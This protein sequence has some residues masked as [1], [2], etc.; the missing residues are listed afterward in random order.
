MIIETKDDVVRLSGSLTRNQWMTI[1]AAANLLLTNHPEGIIVDCSQLSSISEDGAKTFLEA[2]RD[3][4]AA[5][6]RILVVSLPQQVLAVCKTVPG[7][8]SQ[9]PIADTIED[10]R[11]SLRM[12][13][14]PGALRDKK[15]ATT[16]PAKRTTNILVP[17]VANM[18]LTYG[19]VLAARV[20][21]G[22]RAD[23]RLVYFL[24]VP[25]TLPL[26]A[27]LVEEEQSAQK[28]LRQAVESARSEGAVAS[29]HVERVRDAGEGILAAAKNYQVEILVLGATTEPSAGEQHEKFH[30]LVDM[31]I[32]RAPCEVI[33]GRQTPPV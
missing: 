26:N 31:L 21:R 20:S 19:A 16:D 12:A 30:F 2:M 8:R 25:R 1:K 7:V 18:E 11:A 24:E 15:P 23:I 17:I 32:H 3:I 22:S 14:R 9:L 27:P 29:E 28:M 33:V 10:A 6:S 5:K 4:E 13:N